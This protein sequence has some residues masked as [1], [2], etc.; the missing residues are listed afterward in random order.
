MLLQ[1]L[2]KPPLLHFTMLQREGCPVSPVQ[3]SRSPA[4]PS[5]T[6]S[7]VSAQLAGQGGSQRQPVVLGLTGSSTTPILQEQRTEASG[8]KPVTPQRRESDEEM[9]CHG[10][11]SKAFSSSCWISPSDHD[12]ML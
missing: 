2:A 6:L 5:S 11:A 10:G 8:S 1:F 4:T 12:V 3:A 9:H 7:G